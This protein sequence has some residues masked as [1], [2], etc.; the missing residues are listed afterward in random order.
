MIQKTSCCSAKEIIKWMVPNLG[1]IGENVLRKS[2]PYTILILSM[3][4]PFN[5]TINLILDGEHPFINYLLFSPGYKSIHFFLHYPFLLI[6]KKNLLMTSWNYL[7]CHCLSKLYSS[8]HD[9]QIHNEKSSAF[10]IVSPFWRAIG[11]HW[12]CKSC[13]FHE[14]HN[15][16]PLEK[17]QV[18]DHEGFP[19]N[20]SRQHEDHGNNTL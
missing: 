2:S 20:E 10:N 8:S 12:Q 7:S 13:L 15:C 9:Q 14:F 1:V 3:C 16:L 19:T 17:Q 4:F 11:G 18:I 5:C 6:I